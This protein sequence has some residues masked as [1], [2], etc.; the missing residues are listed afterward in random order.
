MFQVGVLYRIQDFLEFLEDNSSTTVDLIRIFP[1]FKNI[2][3]CNL[4]D[5]SLKCNWISEAYD[6]KLSIQKRGLEINRQSYYV[7]KLQM[8]LMDLI[9]KY[10]PSWINMVPRGRGFVEKYVDL[11]TY[12]CLKDACLFES[13]DQNVVDWWDSL[14]SPSRM[15]EKNMKNEIGRKGERLSYEYEERRVG[16]LPKW[17]SIDNNESGYD[18]LSYVDESRKDRLIIEVKTSEKQWNHADYFL[19]KNEWETLKQHTNSVV[20]LW[21]IA[22]NEP[23][24]KT[25]KPSEIEPNIPSDSGNGIWQIVRLPFPTI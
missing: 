2:Q 24:M 20:H 3:T 10:Q 9:I 1:R 13:Y 25:V 14:A 4:V 7:S 11:D 8:Q 15:N 19:S 22:E 21:S 16:V 17:V 5:V 6:G 18:L 23:I 12:Q